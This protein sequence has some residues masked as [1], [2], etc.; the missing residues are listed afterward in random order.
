VELTLQIQPPTDGSGITPELNDAVKNIL[1]QRISGLGIKGA[2][3]QTINQEQLLIQLPDE[4]DAQQ[5]EPV[6]GGI[7]ELDFRQQKPGTET[8]LPIELQIRAGLLR[9]QDELRETG[10]EKALAENQK[11][12]E[13]SESIK[14][15]VNNIRC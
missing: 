4:K 6:L 10:D 8:Q 13:R 7:G 12:L 14:T 11:A 2:A 3:I 9:K 15:V 1:K 5:A